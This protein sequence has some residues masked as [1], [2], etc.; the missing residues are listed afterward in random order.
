M[1]NKAEKKFFDAFIEKLLIILLQKY[2]IFLHLQNFIIDYLMTKK[3]IYTIKQG[4]DLAKDYCSIQERSHQEVFAKLKDW[5]LDS[6]QV[7]QVITIL[8]SKNYLN[9]QRYAKM[10]AISKFHQNKWGK[11]KI[12]YSLKQKDISEKCISIGL[13]EIDTKEYFEVCFGLAD[14]KYKTLKGENYLT[15]KRKTISYLSSKGFEYELINEVLDK[16]NNNKC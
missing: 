3:Q 2:F 4:E 16:L 13:G 5:G 7:D 8:I 10:F 15:K 14:K 12:K 6:E 11:I 1:I 9:E